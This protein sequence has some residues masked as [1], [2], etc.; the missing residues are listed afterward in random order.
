MVERDS[1]KLTAIRS[2][3]QS[4][5]Q[6][7]HKLRNFLTNLNKKKKK[8]Y[9]K[10]RINAIKNDSKKLCNTLKQLNGKKH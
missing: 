8:M 1:A 2:G 9:Y 6:I 10:A 3:Y 5:W 7:Y 4:D